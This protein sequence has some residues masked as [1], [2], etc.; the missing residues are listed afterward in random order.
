MQP[1][2]TWNAHNAVPQKRPGQPFPSSTAPPCPGRVV[3]KPSRLSP[4]QDSVC[5]SEKR[6]RKK[7]RRKREKKEQ[8]ISLPCETSPHSHGTFFAFVNR[9]PPPR[10]L[11]SLPPA[12]PR[13]EVLLFVLRACD[14][15][16]MLESPARTRGY[17]I[18]CVSQAGRAQGAG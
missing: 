14:V 16:P 13:P 10:Q 3:G 7:E 12:P 11:I 17:Q 6:G 9:Q 8:R 4:E 2:H 1:Q 5:G 18:L 15:F